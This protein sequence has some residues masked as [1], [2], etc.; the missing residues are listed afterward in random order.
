[1][2]S[3]FVLFDECKENH[4]PI[5]GIYSTLEQAAKAAVEC[6][7]P[8]VAIYQEF[9]DKVG[10]TREPTYFKPIDGHVFGPV[11]GLTQECLL[12]RE[13]YTIIASLVHRNIAQ[14]KVTQ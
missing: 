6:R 7:D 2:D 8:D 9:L 3:V 10:E 12:C 14:C 1:M 11:R 13:T 4:Y 5:L